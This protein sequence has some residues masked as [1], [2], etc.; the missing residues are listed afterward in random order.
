MV[1]RR[2]HKSDRK[3]AALVALALAT[4]SL[5]IVDTAE[6]AAPARL[7]GVFSVRQVVTASVNMDSAPDEASYTFT[8]DCSTG[9]CQTQYS[10]T[11][12]DGT[13]LTYPLLPEASGDYGGNV[14]HVWSCFRNGIVVEP[15]GY[16]YHE[17]TRL[18]PTGITDDRITG[19]VGVRTV[20]F[21]PTEAGVASNCLPGSY[22]M[23]L[24]GARASGN[25]PPVFTSYPTEPVYPSRDV[26]DITWFEVAAHD[27]EGGAIKFTTS[28]LPTNPVVSCGPTVPTP[29]AIGSVLMCSVTPTRKTPAA[30]QTILVMA[31]DPQGQT[32]S[33]SV[34]LSG[35]RN[36]VIRTD[37]PGA[38]LPV[39]ES[40]GTT[41]RFQLDLT[42]DGKSP[43][44]GS[45]TSCSPGVYAWGA[46]FFGQSITL[47]VK[48]NNRTR[49]KQC[50][51][52]DTR[53]SHVTPIV[54]A[55]GSD[56]VG[57]RIAFDAACG[58]GTVQDYRGV[59]VDLLLTNSA[60]TLRYSVES[61]TGV[62]GTQAVVENLLLHADLNARACMA[63]DQLQTLKTV[64]DAKDVVDLTQLL[65][66][67]A[68][69]Q[70][71]SEVFAGILVEKASKPVSGTSSCSASAMYR[72]AAAALH[73]EAGY[74]FSSG[75]NL[76]LKDE[77]ILNG[78]QSQYRLWVKDSASLGL[79]GESWLPLVAITTSRENV[80]L[81]RT[82]VSGLAR[83]HS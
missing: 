46:H 34:S 49:K 12:P 83:Y 68:F 2:F 32:A 19:F 8:P 48:L 80:M 4:S 67:P 75:S 64:L 11:R 47:E 58:T 31:S 43:F 36:P 54:P 15:N 10:R 79:V 50:D 5:F 55:S 72:A 65:N 60:R 81:T 52:R 22:T 3:N 45:G 39:V 6:A 53:A 9:A 42:N 29:P 35:T 7:Q 66:N 14:I 77:L 26:G 40:I 44:C 62:S 41:D 18:S 37:R 23:E 51:S 16:T 27:P 69:R 24:S 28:A 56:V 61:S 59:V 1:A 71:L 21:T 70:K 38:V 25:Q 33:V 57:Y 74:S 76:L 63:A 30:S 78:S 13:Q 82:M 73:A 17:S 20:T